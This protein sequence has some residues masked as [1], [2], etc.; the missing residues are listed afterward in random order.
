MNDADQMRALAAA[1][2]G[3]RAFNREVAP[4]FIDHVCITSG[5]APPPGSP[6]GEGMGA[7]FSYCELHSASAVSTTLLAAS[8]P[9][10][11]FHA[12]DPRPEMVAAGRSLAGDGEVRNIAFHQGGIEAALDMPLPPFD[13]VVV[14]GSIRG[15]R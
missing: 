2:P 4:A 5:F 15:C 12:I 1:I 8:N 13:Y 10:G 11:D 7:S 9:D 14:H 6:V 3:A